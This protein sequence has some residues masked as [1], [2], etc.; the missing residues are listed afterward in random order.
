MSW[1]QLAFSVEPS[2][3]PS[4][5]LGASVSIPSATMQ[6]PPLEL[7]PVE[8][9]HRRAQIIQ[10]AAQRLDRVLARARDVL[11]ADRR[12]ARRPGNRVDLGAD[13]LTGARVEAR[14]DAGEHPLEHDVAEPVAGGQVRIGASS[15]S[16]SPSALRARAGSPGRA[17]RRA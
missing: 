2:H 9:R 3:D 14:R 13:G 1:R 7:D 17:A 12:L 11:A 6:R 10:R 16:W 4:G 15:T 5:C 8:P